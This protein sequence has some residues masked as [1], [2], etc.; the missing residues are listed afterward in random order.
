MPNATGSL[1][2][3]ILPF[4]DHATPVLLVTLTVLVVVVH[5]Q[6]VVSRPNIRGPYPW[7][8]VGN[9]LSMDTEGQ[10]RTWNKKLVCVFVD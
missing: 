8:L 7:P 1:F 2:F 4:F 5:I 3:E 9:A 10:M 6:S